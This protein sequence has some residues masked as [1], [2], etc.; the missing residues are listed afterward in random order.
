MLTGG[1]VHDIKGAVGL[2]TAVPPPATL[3]GDK[4]YDADHLRDYLASRGTAVV[5][6][7]MPR[8]LRP[9]PFNADA[10]RSRNLVERAFCRI[11]DWRAIATRY[12]KLAR[13][14]LAGVCLAVAVMQ[15][16]Q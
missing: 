15:W 11:K 5:I 14:F 9:A 13:N 4:A 2:L 7:N 6:P 8:R 1:Q 10:Y 3:L 16:L 12:D